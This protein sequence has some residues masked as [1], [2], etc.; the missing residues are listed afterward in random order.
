M[1]GDR[2]GNLTAGV[3][4]VGEKWPLVTVQGIHVS[5]KFSSSDANMLYSYKRRWGTR[6]TGTGREVQR[7]IYFVD[8]GL[9]GACK[10]SIWGKVNRHKAKRLLRG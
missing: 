8:T 5:F 9:K 10:H 6:T 7:A 1:G 2:P 3:D 4:A